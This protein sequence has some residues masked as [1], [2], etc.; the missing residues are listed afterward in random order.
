MSLINVDKMA[1][2]QGGVLAP[3]SSVMRNRIQNGAMIIDQ[4]NAGASVTQTTG[5]VYTL[6][7]WRIIGS[8]TS[9]FTVQQN[10][11]AVIPPTG[12][13]SYLGVTSSAATTPA[14]GDLYRLEQAIEGYNIADLNF[15]TANAKT[16]TASFWVRSSLTGTFG[17]ALWNVDATR[18]YVFS[19]TISAA[20]TWE[21]KTVTIAGDTSGTWNSVNGQGLV[22]QFSIGAGSNN[23]ATTGSWGSTLK[24]GV[25]GQVNVVGTSGATFYITGV[26]LEVG[27][28]ATSYEYENF[29]VTLQKC[30]RYFCKTFNYATAPAQN[31][32]TAGSIGF[33]S[34]AAQ[35]WDAMWR[36][37]VEM[38]AAP[39]AA[40]F[41]TNAASS[42]WSTNTDTPTASLLL[43]GATGLVCRASTP[44]AAG[45]GY[46]IHITAT[47]EL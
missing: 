3:I 11:G 23:L 42:N 45:R 14:S 7:R 37:P 26:Q 24:T 8:V 25:T 40:S 43:I 17:G 33:I 32:G 4:R 19:Y 39:T 2:S 47:A 20:N 15:G 6:D 30:Q 13:K 5:I 46:N 27:T 38:R 41:S 44:A 16:I 34:Q 29:G 22:F 1:D 21:Y 18:A 10:A 28:Q 35:L 9:K 36:F 31:A 12:F